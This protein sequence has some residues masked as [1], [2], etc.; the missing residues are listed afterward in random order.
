[1]TYAAAAQRAQG[2]DVHGATPGTLELGARWSYYRRESGTCTGRL[3]SAYVRVT[4]GGDDGGPY[5]GAG[6]PAWVP[7]G[8]Y[9]EGCQVFWPKPSTERVYG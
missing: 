1:M 4:R 5:G 8:V 3:R 2:K 6:K 9:C 7:V